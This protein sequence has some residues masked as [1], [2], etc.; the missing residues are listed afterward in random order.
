MYNLDVIKIYSVVGFDKSI[1][2][3]NVSSKYPIVAAAV[4]KL[5]ELI[6]NIDNI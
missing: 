3:L 1:L 6:E 4:R 2:R 5:M